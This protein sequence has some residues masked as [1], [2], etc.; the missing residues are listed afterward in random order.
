MKTITIIEDNHDVRE[1]LA[2]ILELSGYAVNT[3][4]N[5]K[6]GIRSVKEKRPDLILCDVM[7]PELDGFG[8]LKILNQDPD[9]MQIPFM[10]LTAKSEK[11]DFRKGMGL[12]ADDYITKPYDDVQLLEAIEMRLDKASRMQ[13]IDNSDSGVRQ[14]FDAAR[15][16]KELNKLS[17]DR[18]LRTYQKKDVIYQEAQY[19][20]WLYFVVEGQVKTVQTNEFDKDLITHVYGPGDFFGFMPLLNGGTYSDRAITLDDTVLRLIPVEDFKILLFNN[21]DFAAKFI[22]MLADHADYNEKQLIDLAYSSVRRKVANAL[23]N[24]A[25]KAK[26]GHIKVMREDIASMAGT[27]KETTIRT[28]SDF[29]NEGIIDVQSSHI[30][31]I[32]EEALV[33]MPQ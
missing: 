33:D 1:N 11:S 31:I 2:E 16:E 14:F 4:E 6:L 20:M 24:L 30:A 25:K 15:G 7:M 8:V 23:L 29:K 21:R 17:E 28:L 19:P 22:N 5:G 10:F 32:D 27:A 12:G 26:D 9:L 13:A 18:E 3:A